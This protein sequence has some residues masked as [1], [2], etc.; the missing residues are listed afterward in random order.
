MRINPGG[1]ASDSLNEN[2]NFIDED[3]GRAPSKR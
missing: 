2:A 3:E 1:G